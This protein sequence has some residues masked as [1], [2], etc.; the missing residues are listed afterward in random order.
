MTRLGTAGLA[1][2]L[3]AVLASAGIL[4]VGG[5]DDPRAPVVHWPEVL[6][7]SLPAG[8]A[9][10]LAWAGRRAS[11]PAQ[12]AVAVATGLTAAALSYGRGHRPG[13][14]GRRPVAPAAPPGGRLTAGHLSPRRPQ[15]C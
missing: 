2:A 6:T 10:G 4:I 1:F 8:V 12:L 11:R 5:V 15:A 13:I 14:C 7:L 3:L 9:V